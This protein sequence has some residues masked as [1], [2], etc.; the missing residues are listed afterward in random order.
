M[1]SGACSDLT[2]PDVEIL[3]TNELLVLPLS[4]AAPAPASATFY[5]VNSRETVQPLIHPD[6]FNTLF[7]E[8]RFPAGCVESGGGATLSNTD[9]VQVTATPRTGAYGFTLS[10]S[11]LTF[12]PAC[13]AT[14]THSFGRYGDLSVADG[15]STYLDR[16]AYA[17]A[18]DLWREITPDRWQVTPGSGPAGTDRLGGDLERP[19]LF[20]L[21]APR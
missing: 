8:L 19:G 14:A 2:T 20:V 3:S 10:P 5:I 12:T 16:G 1:V 15:S 7:L 11:D 4:G 17:A 18:L 21:A 6:G 13:R 9:S